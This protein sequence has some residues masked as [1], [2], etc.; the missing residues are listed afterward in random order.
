VLN[1]Q[2]QRPV[3]QPTSLMCLF[4]IHFLI[5]CHFQLPSTSTCSSIS[6]STFDIESEAI[7]LR[8]VSGDFGQTVRS[9]NRM[10]LMLSLYLPL[11]LSFPPL[12]LSLSLCLAR[13][14]H[15]AHVIN[16]AIACWLKLRCQP[17]ARCKS[18]GKCICALLF[19]GVA[20][21]ALSLPFSFILCLLSHPLHVY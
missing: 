17:A 4:S 15:F 3:S 7:R 10:I 13:R 8:T 21:V 14:K 18:C 12:S 5:L 16:L 6:T 2:G 19:V 1:Q 11:S 20:F 9:M